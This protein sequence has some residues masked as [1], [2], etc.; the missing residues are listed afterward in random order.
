MV[1]MKWWSVAMPSRVTVR[2]KEAAM[3]GGEVHDHGPLTLVIVP[4]Y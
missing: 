3:D 1:R 2:S 4:H